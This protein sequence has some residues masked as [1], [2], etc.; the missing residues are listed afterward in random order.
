VASDTT[1]G[2]GGVEVVLAGGT[3]HNVIF[4]GASATLALE[5]SSALTGSISGWQANDRIDLSDILFNDGT[6][7]LAYAQ[8]GDNSG[9]TLTVS[10]GTHSA[11]LNLLGQYS[12][13][14]FAIASD[15][16]GGTS[17]FDPSLAPQAQLAVSQHA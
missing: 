6:T 10:D 14:D 5:D 16:H 1:I 13:A 8:N 15:G 11:T 9:G 12:A 4:G 7:S 3:A 2:A 17:V